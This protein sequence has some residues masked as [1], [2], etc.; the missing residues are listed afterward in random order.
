MHGASRLPHCNVFAFLLEAGRLGLSGSKIGIAITI[1]AR[2]LAL[3]GSDIED[4]ICGLRISYLC[5][6]ITTF[7]RR[8]APPPARILHFFSSSS[9]R[10]P[11]PECRSK[12]A[13]LAVLLSRPFG[14]SIQAVSQSVSVLREGGRECALSLC[15]SPLISLPTMELIRGPLIASK[16]RD[17][18]L[19][20][21]APVVSV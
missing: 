11:S 5:I 4:G 18:A 17:W 10:L 16:R 12:Y 21:W 7:D 3:S 15:D 1:F 9:S 20:G 8:R 6:A 2:G 19:G 13:R 14:E